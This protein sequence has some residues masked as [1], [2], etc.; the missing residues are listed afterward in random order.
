MIVLFLF[1]CWICVLR[2][3]WIITFSFQKVQLKLWKASWILDL[4]IAGRLMHYVGVALELMGCVNG[5]FE[6]DGPHSEVKWAETSA[7]GGS[8]R[9]FLHLPSFYFSLPWFIF[10]HILLCSAHLLNY[11]MNG[12]C[13]VFF[14]TLKTIYL[15]KKSRLFTIKSIIPTTC[16]LLVPH[17]ICFS[18]VSSSSSDFFHSPGT[19]SLRLFIASPPL[20]LSCLVASLSNS[21]EIPWIVSVYETR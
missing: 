11:F 5:H 9:L 18:L 21:P 6:A 1:G 13:F 2:L 14:T 16:S 3:E 12:K 7:H 19:P 10:F 15:A 4:Q 8:F 17:A 20:I